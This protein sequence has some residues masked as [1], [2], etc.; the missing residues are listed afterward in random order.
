M[1]HLSAAAGAAVLRAA[2]MG[3]EVPGDVAIREGEMGEVE[4]ALAAVASRQ[5]SWMW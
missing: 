2:C 5:R 1:A 4:G 3:V